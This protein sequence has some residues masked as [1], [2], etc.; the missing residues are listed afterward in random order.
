MAARQRRVAGDVVQIGLGDLEWLDD[1]D[2]E[3][4]AEIERAYAADGFARAH[5]DRGARRTMGNL[6]SL[7]FG[8]SDLK[9]VHMGSLGQT[10]MARFRSSVAGMKPHHW[11]ARPEF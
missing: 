4:N 9:T 11:T 6:A 8:G 7:A 2:P 10:R 5:L 3:L 1:G